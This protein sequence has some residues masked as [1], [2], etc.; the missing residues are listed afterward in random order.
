M[1]VGSKIAKAARTRT[2]LLAALIAM[3]VCV[4]CGSQ[5]AATHDMAK[6]AQ[7]YPGKKWNFK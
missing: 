7:Q 5:P 3:V 4:G 2:A 1:P 6:K